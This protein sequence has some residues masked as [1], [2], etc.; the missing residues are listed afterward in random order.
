[1]RRRI[2]NQVIIYWG[3]LSNPK[4]ST[5]RMAAKQKAEHMVKFLTRPTS[6]KNNPK[7]YTRWWY[8]LSFVWIILSLFTPFNYFINIKSIQSL[9]HFNKSLIQ[10]TPVCWFLATWNCDRS[11]VLLPTCMLITFY[12]LHY[13]TAD[14]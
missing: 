6:A 10:V 2:D 14:K 7:N 4:Q 12:L 5:R 8:L 3:V 1:M 11:V 13:K 9:V